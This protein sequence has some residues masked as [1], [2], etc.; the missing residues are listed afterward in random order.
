MLP[1]T[2]IEENLSFAYISAIAADAGI[3]V[4]DYSNA[5][6]GMDGKFAE[7]ANEDGNSCRETGFGIEFQLKASTNVT[8]RDGS[9]YYELKVKNYKDLIKTNIGMARILIVYS[10][11]NDR[12][13][14]LSADANQLVL[15]ECAWWVS[16]KGKPVTENTAKKTISIPETQR[17]DSAELIRLIDLIKVGDEL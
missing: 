17:L 4:R 16:L 11:P 15:R 14:W 13:Q 2:K 9:I 6:Y 7:V 5:D 1:E 8:H 10:L 12:S 3:I